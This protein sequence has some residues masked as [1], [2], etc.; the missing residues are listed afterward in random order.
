[1]LPYAG[2]FSRLLHEFNETIR[3]KK[4]NATSN[5]FIVMRFIVGKE[6][7]I[8]PKSVDDSPMM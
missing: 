5:F 4:A 6:I 8:K 2:H 3:D 1:L 7:K